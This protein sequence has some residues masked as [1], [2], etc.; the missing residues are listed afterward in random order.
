M[1]KNKKLKIG[2][3][4]KKAADKLNAAALPGERL[5]YIN[6]EEARMLKAAGGAG[7]PFNESGVP[8]Y[9]GPWVAAALGA[10]V[11]GVIGSKSKEP[12][13]PDLQSTTREGMEA[14]AELF[15]I[16]QQLIWA[17]RQ[18]LKGS[19]KVGDKDVPYDFTG[20]GWREMQTDQTEQEQISADARAKLDLDLQQKY[21]SGMALEQLKRFKE[22]NP[23][24]WEAKQKSGEAILSQLALGSSYDQ[25]Q[26]Q[27][28]VRGA[29]SARGNVYGRAN[30]AQEAKA[31]YS[32]GQAMLQQRIAMAQQHA[33][34]QPVQG[35]GARF[36][37]AQVGYNPQPMGL[38]QQSLGFA[39]SGYSTAAQNYSN[40]W[41]E[42]LG[43]V[44]GMYSSYLLGRGGQGG[45][46]APGGGG[47]MGGGM[48]G[49][50]GQWPS[51]LGGIRGGGNL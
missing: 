6:P 25:T 1:K 35:P 50:G 32:E 30:I 48:G 13:Q 17:A 12:E 3:P 45:T 24:Q 38:T 9:I 34:G 16:Q 21:G 23:L 44:T 27:E 20:M 33:M 43:M 42:G 8:A 19:V 2:G 7:V 31:T 10:V 4:L 28:G 37:P 5:A 14:E 41:M 26:V 47:G 40:P 49:G 46:P 39:Q 36:A 11:G 15:P 51:Q 29:Q 18:G 22:M